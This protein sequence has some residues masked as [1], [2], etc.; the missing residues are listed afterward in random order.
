M[1]NYS[2]LLDDHK[3]N[4]YHLISSTNDHQTTKE[5]DM[6]IRTLV[7]HHRPTI[8]TLNPHLVFPQFFLKAITVSLGFSRPQLDAT[9]VIQGQPGGE[10]SHGSHADLWL[11]EATA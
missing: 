3:L 11:G 9:G 2:E 7:D 6:T 1:N 4:L 8:A 5:L 10:G